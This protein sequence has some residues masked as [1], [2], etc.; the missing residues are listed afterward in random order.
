MFYTEDNEVYFQGTAVVKSLISKLKLMFF[1]TQRCTD[2]KNW[3]R[4]SEFC[5]IDFLIVR[6]VNELM[7]VYGC[8][9]CLRN[10]GAQA[11]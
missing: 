2:I 8:L 7:E 10:T 3:S 4:N 1:L 5:S 6:H 11:S 9:L